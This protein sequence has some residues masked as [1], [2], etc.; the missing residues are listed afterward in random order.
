ML[1]DVAPV[2]D[3]D[4]DW[5]RAL[6]IE[7]WGEPRVV[8]MCEA[9]DP[10]FLPAL[11]ARIGD[12]RVGLL[13]YAI[14]G[15]ECEVVTIRSLQEGVGVA[16]TLLDAVR[17]VAVE[18]GC[19]RLWLITTNDNMRALT[20]YQR[21][22]MDLVAVHRWAVDEARRLKP[23]IPERGELGIPIMHELEL[24]LLLG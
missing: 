1:I 23:G 21:W 7:S 24:E 8:R 15:D 4:R 12:D 6:E 3:Q 22:G 19:K 14:R 13:A 9:I 2:S 16:R 17:E 10:T 11:V 5:A 18:A 20:V